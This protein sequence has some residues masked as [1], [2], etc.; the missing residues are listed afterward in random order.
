MGYCHLLIKRLRIELD[1]FFFPRKTKLT[2]NLDDTGRKAL[3]EQLVFLK[4]WGVAWSL[5]S[6]VSV[7]LFWKHFYF[8]SSSFP[9]SSFTY[10]WETL[11]EK[12][13]GPWYKS[14]G[15]IKHVAVIFNYS[16]RE[17]SS[18][19]KRNMHALIFLLP[20][21]LFSFFRHCLF[22]KIPTGTPLQ[23]L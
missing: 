19:K 11:V 13:L 9:L 18:R 21:F 6:W 2:K 22:F 20:F 23:I 12:L 15:Y 4:S 17:E 16:N 1:F 8:S 10:I 5:W 7:I 14:W 3:W